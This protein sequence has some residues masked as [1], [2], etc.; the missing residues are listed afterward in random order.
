M[1][2]TC[3]AA[4]APAIAI[5]ANVAATLICRLLLRTVVW[6]RILDQLGVAGKYAEADVE[7]AAD[8]PGPTESQ[9][10]CR[11]EL[12]GARPNR[13]NNAAVD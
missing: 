2:P 6:R 12:P 1:P 5:T 3:A 8:A 13:I 7:L 10:P 9:T 4:V 11:L